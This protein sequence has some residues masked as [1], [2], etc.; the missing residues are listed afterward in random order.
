MLVREMA[1]N[2]AN[3]RAPNASAKCGALRSDDTEAG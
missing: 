2:A 3:R 1:I